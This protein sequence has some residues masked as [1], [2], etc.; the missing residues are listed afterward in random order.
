VSFWIKLPATS[1]NL[2]AAFDTAAIALD[3]Y[4]ELEADAADAFRIEATGRNPEQCGAV[5]NNLILET[6]KRLLEREGRAVVPL[7]VRMKNGIPLGMGCGSSAAGRLA[8]IALANHFGQ[9]GWGGEEI[10][11]EAC[12]LEGHPDNAAACWLGGL[13]LAA[14]EGR[15]VHVAE[16]MPPEDWSALVVLPVDPLA[17]SKARSVLPEKYSRADVVANVQ[18]AALLGISFAQGRGELLAAAMADRL[19]QPYRAKMCPLLPYLL[20]LAGEAGILGV[21]LSGAGPSVLVIVAGREQLDGAAE[22]IRTELRGGPSAEILAVEF[23][24]RGAEGTGIG[25]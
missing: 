12:A 19:H 20:P 6:Y 13:V 25:S 8:A 10:L 2:G 3:F 11:A 1:A 21:A 24:R 22:R 17:T 7:A 23:V 18:A 4:L 14:M 9:L 16:V 15:Q 5:E